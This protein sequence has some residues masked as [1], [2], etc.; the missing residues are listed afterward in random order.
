MKR[1]TLL[2]LTMTVATAGDT[3]AAPQASIPFVFEK[4][5]GQVDRQVRYF[6]RTQRAG[7]WLV[8]SGAVLSVEQN[9]QRAVLRMKLDGARPHPKIDGADP[10]PGR[11]NYF[12]EKRPH[13]VA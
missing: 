12:T 11:T 6:G 7:L 9:N 10:L 13:P 3:V 1:Q 2:W 5:A 4:N 8:D